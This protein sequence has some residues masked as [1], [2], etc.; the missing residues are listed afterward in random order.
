MFALVKF[1]P[2]WLFTAPKTAPL[3]REG[4]VL[5]LLGAADRLIDGYLQITSIKTTTTARIDTLFSFAFKVIGLKNAAPPKT[6]RTAKAPDFV[7]LKRLYFVST[8]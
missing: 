7:S 8:P 5:S 2:N 4:I 3:Q 1:V 6:T